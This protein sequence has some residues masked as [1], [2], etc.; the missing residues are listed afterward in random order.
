MGWT[1]FLPAEPVNQQIAT[2]RDTTE[3]VVTDPG[4]FEVQPVRKSAFLRAWNPDRDMVEK[5]NTLQQENLQLEVETQQLQQ[6]NQVYETR[7]DSTRQV[8]QTLQVSPE[9][10]ENLIRSLD[11]NRNME[12]INNSFNQ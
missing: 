12:L 8:I 6:V 2:P 10:R 4:E 1:S 3:T 5:T 9:I 11:V 7:L